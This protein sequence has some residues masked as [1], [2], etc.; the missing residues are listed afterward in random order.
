MSRWEFIPS[1]IQEI[2]VGLICHRRHPSDYERTMTLKDRRQPKNVLYARNWEA[3]ARV[4][5]QWRTWAF[6]H[7][8]RIFTIRCMLVLVAYPLKPVLLLT[9]A[10]PG[11]YQFK[12]TPAAQVVGH[13]GQ[14]GVR[15]T[16]IAWTRADSKLYLDWDSSNAMQVLNMYNGRTESL[17]FCVDT[18]WSFSDPLVG[19]PTIFE[20]LREPCTFDSKKFTSSESMY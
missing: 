1:E 17:D 4:C 3:C 16:Y 7:P 5:K 14:F 12:H 6:A 9:L 19:F 18:T 13:R 2:I 15:P 20:A 11:V 8:L 10:S